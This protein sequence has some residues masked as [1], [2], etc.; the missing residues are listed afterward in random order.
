M[1]VSESMWVRECVS[2]WVHVW[3]GE[4]VWVSTCVSVCGYRRHGTYMRFPIAAHVEWCDGPRAVCCCVSVSGTLTTKWW[5]LKHCWPNINIQ[6]VSEVSYERRVRKPLSVVA[7]YRCLEVDVCL[8]TFVLTVT[9][10]EVAAMTS[11]FGT[12]WP[13]VH[14]GAPKPVV[15]AT[16]L[17]IT[18]SL[19]ISVS[20][21]V[22]T[23]VSCQALHSLI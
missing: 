11:S 13:E 9:S 14:C 19:S 18:S 12:R 21:S 15:Q 3:V 10:Q 22:T 23:R 8:L 16:R 5:H 17:S 4:W 1:W 6:W 2:Q 20:W 7:L